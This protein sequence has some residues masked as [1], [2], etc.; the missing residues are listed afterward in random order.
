MA[1]PCSH[2]QDRVVQTESLKYGYILGTVRVKIPITVSVSHLGRPSIMTN[3]ETDHHLNGLQ[4]PR[5]VWSD[6]GDHPIYTSSPMATTF[7]WPASRSFLMGGLSGLL[8]VP[9]TR[10][11]CSL[12]SSPLRVCLVGPPSALKYGI[13][14]NT[15]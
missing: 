12:P 1:R 8:S 14:G 5:H 13:L 3:N 2:L 4:T 10:S 15:P 11:D 9:I 7:S 6:I